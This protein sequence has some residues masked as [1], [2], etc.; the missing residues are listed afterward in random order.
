MRVQCAACG[1]VLL[2][3]PEKA[4]VPNLKARCR[5]GH[6]FAVATAP[7][8]P[9]AAPPPRPAA[10]PVAP[11]APQH[12]ATPPVPA[13]A[14]SPA[15]TRTPP[16]AEAAPHAAAP[17]TGAPPTPPAARAPERIA[18]AP[19]TARPP[20]PVPAAGAPPQPA[21]AAGARQA[22]RPP[23]ARPTAARSAAG[24]A[25][26][27]GA[28]RPVPTRSAARPA[29]AA[30]WRQCANH[31]DAPSRHYCR[32]CTKGYC[33][34]CVQR[35][36]E[37]FV[38]G[39]C[40]Q[41]CVP[42]EKHAE[43]Q[44][45]QRDRARPLFAEL[46]TIAGYPLRDRLG[47][48]LLVIFVYAASFMPFYAWLFSTGVLLWYV[49]FALGRVADGNLRDF[50]PDF[51]DLGD[52]VA[53]VRLS[54]A[55][56]LISMGPLLVALYLTPRTVLHDLREHST[57]A[58]VVPE[59]AGERPVHVVRAA[60]FRVGEPAAAAQV[61]A[62]DETTV[63]EHEEPASDE[64]A[65]DTAD[66]DGGD[67]GAPVETGPPP[68]EDVRE[69]RPSLLA[70][71]ALALAALWALAYTPVAL[72]VAALS[73]SFLSTIN[74]VVGLDT[75]RRMGATYWQAWVL[76]FGVVIAQGV[77]GAVLSFIPFLGGLLRA[78]VDAY[79]GLAV[80]CTLGLAVY[81][82]APELDWD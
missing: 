1:Q 53:P 66:P 35:V 20:A 24:A 65:T 2:V 63:P 52:L 31:A 47:F 58:P 69:P 26:A 74:P 57:A 44:R 16:P 56:M 54:I 82:K 79:A 80:A 81:K 23:S 36:R 19:A 30:E 43:E 10:A 14:P 34:A 55:A 22:T 8:P 12:A 13:R 11:V 18:T 46:G 5:C 62:P 64:A 59:Q 49:F 7:R 67:A 41:L 37:A 76:Y 25:T 77:M 6:V 48:V 61:S 27:A 32:Q 75:I 15:A 33:G 4:A 28:A 9:D 3:P 70:Y 71:L 17:R 39:A 45:R 42:I 50:A 68:P 51:R 38:C 72:A 29:A 73:R 78:F 40:D 21:S 60:G